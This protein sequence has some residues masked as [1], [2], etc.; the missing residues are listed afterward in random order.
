MSDKEMYDM[1]RKERI[2]FLLTRIRM[3]KDTV[4][5]LKTQARSQIKGVVQ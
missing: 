4:K 1:N 5:T 3:D 2:Q